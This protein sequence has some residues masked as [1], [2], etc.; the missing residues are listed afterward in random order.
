[1][2]LE[3]KSFAFVIASVVTLDA[4]AGPVSPLEMQALL[5]T[6]SDHLTFYGVSGG[7]L[8]GQKIIRELTFQT[9]RPATWLYFSLTFTGS[10]RQPVATVLSKLFAPII[11]H[12]MSTSYVLWNFQT[13]LPHQ[14]IVKFAGTG[15][16]KKLQKKHF[17]LRSV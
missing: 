15:I 3:G 7:R 13:F 8:G 11:S 9:R 5:D 10:E 16:E 2:R 12:L 6:E 1:M 4:N 17:V 14:M